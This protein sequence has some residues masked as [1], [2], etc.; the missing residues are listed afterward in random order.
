M[1]VVFRAAGPASLRKAALRTTSSAVQSRTS[2]RGC[3]HFKRAL[4]SSARATLSASSPIAAP[5]SPT[6][7][8][9]GYPSSPFVSGLGDAVFDGVNANLTGAPAGDAAAERDPSKPATTRG[10]PTFRL[11]DGKGE[12]LPGVSED[13]VNLAKDA[14]VHMMRT[15]L[16]LPALDMILYNAQRQG[17]ISFMMTS[18]GEEAAV[19]GSAAAL[20]MKDEIFAQYREMGVLLYRGFSLEKVMDQV[21]GVGHFI[22]Q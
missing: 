16:L 5:S 22:R 1:S 15:M 17:R 19:V 13:S 9:P 6:G 8:L 21:S 2:S 3:H 4:A 20:D 7:H 10:I 12:L 18:H 14:A 11:L